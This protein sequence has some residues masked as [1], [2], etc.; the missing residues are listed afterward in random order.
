MDNIFDVGELMD[1]STVEVGDTVDNDVFT[2]D[3]DMLSAEQCETFMRLMLSD[4][5]ILSDA[6]KSMDDRDEW[7]ENKIAFSLMD[8]DNNSLPDA[9]VFY[10]R[11]TPMRVSVPISDDVMLDYV[12]CEGFGSMVMRAV[13]EIA[14][15]TAE[16]ILVNSD[17][18]SESS[19]YSHFDGWIKQAVTGS[20]M[21]ALDGGDVLARMRDAM[22]DKFKRDNQ[23]MRYYVSE[24]CREQFGDEI[25]DIPVKFVDT[26]D[27]RPFVLLTHRQNLYAGFRQRVYMSTWRDSRW[28]NLREG[29]TDFVATIQI[30]SKIAHAPAAVL[31]L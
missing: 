30:D 27:E 25:R 31:A 5:P 9:G 14:G 11:T 21:I 4:R 28:K 2:K 8:M 13:C 17:V 10:I 18:D 12:E 6:R 16:D 23:N 26:L 15:R 29:C 19:R 24:N 7:L 22:P 1:A 20:P 3:T